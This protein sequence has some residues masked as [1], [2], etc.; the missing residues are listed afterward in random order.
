MVI[1]HDSQRLLYRTPFGAALV[2]SQVR[3]RLYVKIGEIPRSVKLVFSFMDQKA[4]QVNMYYIDSLAGGSLYQAQITMPDRVGLVWYYFVLESNSRTYYYGNNEKRLGGLGRVYEKDPLPYQI[5]VYK[6]DFKTPD[7]FKDA[8]V[9]QIFPDRFSKE[10]MDGLKNTDRQGIIPRQWE[11]TP[12]YKAEQFG[13]Q[14]LA[15]DFFGGSLVG[16]I[17]KLDYLKEL[18]ITAIYLNPIFEAF[19]NHRYDVGDYERVDPILGTN[20]DF[21]RL[22]QEAKGRGIRIILDGVFSHTGSNSRYFNKEG[23]YPS[24]GAYQSKDSP[25]Y[26]WYSFKN[27]PDDYEAWWG[28]KTLPHTRELEPSFMDYILT[29][30]KAIVKR[31]L[32]YGGSGWRLDVADELPPEFLRALRKAVKEKMPEAVIIGE[33]WEDAT[34]KLSYGKLREYLL[35]EKLDSVMNYPLRGA[36]IDFACKRI[37]AAG[38]A[39]RLMSLYENYPK[40]AFYS[41][42]NF[43]SSHD[44][45][46]IITLLADCPLSKD[47]TKDEKA[48]FRLNRAQLDLAKKRLGNALLLL[49]TLPGVPCI[50]YGDEVGMEGYEDPFNRRTFP[51]QALDETILSLYKRMIK[52]RKDNRVLVTGE[53]EILYSYKSCLAFARYDKEKFLAVAVN[54]GSEPTFT[55]L[56]L[57]RFQPKQAID[58]ES[59]ANISIVDG[60]ICFDLA[61]LESRIIELN[62]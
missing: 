1:E 42:L 41:L 14:Y 62:K 34:N 59:K 15:N 24:L 7:W 54:M 16:I 49:M 8:I 4:Q 35:G 52:L 30:D 56:D 44:V 25:Y 58:L 48:V 5:S 38:F 9:Y 22:C 40:E 28:I 27:H 47:L 3:L 46:R 36:I 2:S 31:W 12:Y 29:S 10:G 21:K 23:T 18:G 45:A 37:D 32:D 17:N 51:W 13:G 61:A 11:E 53:F 20:D 6:K 39:M 19:S 55:R 50:Y 33:V 60:I 57:A 43:L 26:S